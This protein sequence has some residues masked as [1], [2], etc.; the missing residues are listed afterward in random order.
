MKAM[1]SPLNELPASKVGKREP[2]EPKRVVRDS[3]EGTGDRAA[4]ILWIRMQM[5]RHG[6]SYD[7]LVQAGCFD[8]GDTRQAICYRN[9]E[10]RTWDGQ[11]DMPDWLQRA[12]NAG[13]S[14][15]HFRI[16]LF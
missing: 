3:G 1:R 2:F 16:N 10:G 15:E 14:I 9:A 5:V 11:G 7:D 13:Q 12:I 8:T 6:V 4:A